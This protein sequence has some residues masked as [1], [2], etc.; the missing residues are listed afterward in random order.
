MIL[1]ATLNL[2]K[3]LVKLMALLAAVLL[4]PI[5]MSTANLLGEDAT[6]FLIAVDF[7]ASTR[8]ATPVD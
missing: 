5:G 7:A 6:P 2:A 1:H 4:T 3:Q 8:L